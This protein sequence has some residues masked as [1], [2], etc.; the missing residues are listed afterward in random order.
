MAARGA[1]IAGLIWHLAFNWKPPS[2]YVVGRATRHLN[3]NRE[4]R[5]TEQSQGRVVR[6]DPSGLQ[7]DAQPPA[8]VRAEDWKT[9]RD[10]VRPDPNGLFADAL[11]TRRPVP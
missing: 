11:M 3:L 10:C 9:F 4:Y 8:G 7:P 1:V 5:L 6:V 2:T